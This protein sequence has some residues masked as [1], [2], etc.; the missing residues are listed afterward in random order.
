MISLNTLRQTVESSDTKSGLIFDLIV[1][2]LIVMS[3]IVFSIE[4]IPNMD[5]TV[6]DLLGVLELAIVAIFS[7]EYLLRILV[8]Q[9]KKRFIFSMWGV[10][11]L[12]AILP[13][14]L[15][16]LGLEFD[17]VMLRAFRLIRLTRL[18]KLARYNKAMAR[19]GLA[20]K[21]AREDLL[22]SLGATCIMLFVAS[23]GIYQFENSVQ[24]D[25]FGSVF[26]SLWW[27]LSTLTT[28]G[29]GDVYPMT[30]GGKVFTGLVLMIGLGI[31][32][33]PAGI[34]A[35]SLTEARERQKSIV[36]PLVRIPP[37]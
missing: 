35:S 15:F 19:L 5:H 8:S 6:V 33:L 25:R 10:I 21:I 1:Q 30:L 28:V 32:A 3:L 13:F 18:L 9:D 37:N 4:T 26:D 14:Y 12:L 24:P 17:L 27:A 23:F 20:M 29:Y 16:F 2:A 31:V 34:I 36:D 22:V 7:I 11:D